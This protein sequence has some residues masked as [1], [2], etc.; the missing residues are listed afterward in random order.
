MGSLKVSNRV[1]LKCWNVVTPPSAKVRGRNQLEEDSQSVRLVVNLQSGDFEGTIWELSR[2]RPRVRV[3]SSPPFTIN[4]LARMPEFR[5]GTKRHRIGTSFSIVS[6]L[7][8][9]S[10]HFLREQKRNHRV[11]RIPFLSRDR[12]S[13]RIE[14]H[15]NRRMAE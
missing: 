13:V 4:D 15:S 1:F 14:C 7:V 2:Q 11:L 12:L 8:C 10:L 9:L 6:S 5:V 3:P